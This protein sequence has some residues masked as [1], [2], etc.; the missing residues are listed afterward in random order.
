MSRNIFGR[1]CQWDRYL[2]RDSAA[3][4]FRDDDDILFTVHEAILLLLDRIQRLAP[5]QF[6][7]F[8]HSAQ[9]LHQLVQQIGR[10]RFQ[11][12]QLLQQLGDFLFDRPE[13]R[14]G[15]RLNGT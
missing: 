15:Q 5:R 9:L 1:F 14:V 10:D 7:H 6:G 13:V 11:G 4:C 3:N 2:E 8:A 12:A